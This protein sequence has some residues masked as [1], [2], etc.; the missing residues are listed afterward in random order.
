MQTGGAGSLSWSWLAETRPKASSREADPKTRAAQPSGAVLIT[1][2]FQAESSDW[3]G[4]QCKPHV[5]RRDLSSSEKLSFPYDGC[6][7]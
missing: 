2:I 5:S 1:G 4:T 3:A 7:Q 6:T